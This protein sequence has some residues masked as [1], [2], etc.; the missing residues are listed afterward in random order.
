M[1]KVLI[2]GDSHVF[3]LIEA[4][5]KSNYKNDWVIN[6]IVGIGPI[7]NMFN[8]DNGILKLD[9]NTGDWPVNK[10][11]KHEQFE[12]WYQDARNR[13]EKYQEFELNINYYDC[14]AVYGGKVVNNHWYQYQNTYSKQINA[15]IL[16]DELKPT[17]HYRL[18]RE[19]RKFSD[20]IAVLSMQ[21]PLMNEAA[22]NFKGVVNCNLSGIKSMPIDANFNQVIK[23]YNKVLK[24]I[25][26][27]FIP[28]PIKTLNPENNATAKTYQMPNGRDFEHLNLLGANV[29]LDDLIQRLSSK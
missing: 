23:I 20:K 19:I 10:F 27:E 2:I 15:E 18:V 8:F 9:D 6:L 24:E 3:R 21:T 13:I 29:V 26:S 4:F 16:M 14:I 11:T 12:I 1:K 5:E 28:L 17:Q 25:G 7:I 22:L